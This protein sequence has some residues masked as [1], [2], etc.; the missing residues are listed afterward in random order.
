MVYEREAVYS[1]GCSAGGQRVKQSQADRRVAFDQRVRRLADRHDAFLAGDAAI[2]AQTDAGGYVADSDSSVEEEEGS[3][4]G[5][6]GGEPSAAAAAARRGGAFSSGDE[7]ESSSSWF[8]DEMVEWFEGARASR[9][10]DAQALAETRAMSSAEADSSRT[11]AR[12]V[13][14]KALVDGSSGTAVTYFFSR[15]KVDEARKWAA[16]GCNPLRGEA[17]RGGGKT[18]PCPCSTPRLIL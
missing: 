8:E 3:G 16:A 15:K 14:C 9:A 18:A 13:Q 11:V 12:R 2:L 1:G 17:V 5:A 4:R 10:T 7:Y 6:K